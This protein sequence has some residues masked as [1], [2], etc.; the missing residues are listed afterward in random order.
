M[1]RPVCLWAFCYLLLHFLILS[2]NQTESRLLP[3]EEGEKLRFV[4][5]VQQKSQTKN[6]VTL[7]LEDVLFQSDT[8]TKHSVIGENQNKESKQKIGAICYMAKQI[9]NPKNQGLPELGCYVMVE[10]IYKPFYEATNQGQFDQKSYYETQNIHFS[11]TKGKVIKR[12]KSYHWFREKLWLLKQRWQQTYEELCSEKEAG[13]LTSVVLGDKKSLDTEVKD[14]FSQNGIAHILAVSGV[15]LSIL[16]MGLYKILKKVGVPEWIRVMGS[17]FLIILY[18]LMIHAGVATLRA[19]I[20]LG[21]NLCSKLFGRTYDMKVATAVAATCLIAGNPAFLISAGFVLSFMAILALLFF[22]PFMKATFGLSEQ[23][24]QITWLRKFWDA[25]LVTFSIT[26]FLLP[27]QTYYYYEIYPYS[28]FLNLIVLPLFTI[29]LYLG[30]AGGLVGMYLP[31][32]GKFLLFPCKV[33]FVFYQWLCK[34]TEVFAGNRVIIGKPSIVQVLIFYVFVMAVVYLGTVIGK[35]KKEK[36]KSFKSYRIFVIV[37][38]FTACVVLCW[39]VRW[40]TQV[41]FLDVGQGDCCVIKEKGGMNL[42][43]DGGSSDVSSCGEYRLIPY[44]KAQGIERIDYA[45][46][47]HLDGDHYSAIL[48]AILSQKESGIEIQNLVLSAYGKVGEKYAEFVE[49]VE[50]TGCQV[51]YINPGDTLTVG[52]DEDEALIL[53]CLFPYGDEGFV[54]T[55]EQSMILYGQVG[56]FDMLF[57]GDIGSGTETTFLNYLAKSS[58]KNLIQNIDL[59]KV[60]HHGSSGSTSEEFLQVVRPKVSIIS[61]GVNNQYGHP[62]KETLQRLENCGSKVFVTSEMG[63]ITVDVFSGKRDDREFRISRENP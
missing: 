42:L 18:G 28:M 3:F 51:V 22:Y 23:R 17:L 13:F 1:K 41:V 24:C 53:Q 38:C 34:G 26:F 16:G 35:K 33:I 52:D 15:H 39:R 63:Q 36:E 47:S 54:D 49:Q 32:L 45:F 20:M 55:N 29:V 19:I 8:G 59:L 12:T 62:H 56:D 27:V 48:E 50:G 58:S 2:F 31:F 9:S 6:G 43:I 37:V 25:F 44:L 14:L 21:I 30:F 5:K 40:N 61:C 46:L 4:G 10:G 7:Y 11:I 60:A 57:T